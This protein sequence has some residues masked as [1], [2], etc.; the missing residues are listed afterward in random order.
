M[1]IPNTFHVITHR[2]KAAQL[3]K[4]HKHK[5]KYKHDTALLKDLI[6]KPT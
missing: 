3:Y 2:M 5:Y 6:S 1:G 4:G